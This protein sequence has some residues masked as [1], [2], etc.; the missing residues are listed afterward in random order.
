MLRLFFSRFIIY[1]I[2][3]LLLL[4]VTGV[5]P[6]YE[7]SGRLKTLWQDTYVYQAIERVSDWVGIAED[8]VKPAAYSSGK[9]KEKP[10]KP[11]WKETY[12]HRSITQ[13]DDWL[14]TSR[15]LTADDLKGRIILLD[16]W[17]FCCINCIHVI[18]DLQY[19]EEKFGHDLTVIGV[20]SAKFA[21]ERDR[22]NIRAA[23]LRYGVEHPVVN[24]A[25]FQVWQSFGA[26]AWPTF[27]LISPEGRPVEI[28]SGEGHRDALEERISD[29]IEEYEGRLNN[30][31]LPI[32]LEADKAP[33]ML[34]NFPGKLAH[35]PSVPAF[36]NQ[37]ILFIANSSDH[38]IL[39]TTLDGAILTTIGSGERGYQDGDYAT[40]Q[41]DKPQGL[42]YRDNALYVAD[43]SNHVLRKIDLASGEVTTIAGTGK[44]GYN[45]RASK[46]DA[47]ST[48]LASPWD[49]AFYPDENHITIAMA[50]THQLWVYD[51]KNDKV[52]VLAGNG[53]ESIDDGEY[54][55]NSLSQPSGLSVHD[56]KLYFVD[57][58]T[59]SLRVLEDGAITTLIGTGLF[60]FGFED[61]TRGIG[62][63]QHPL[64]IHADDT[65]VY[66]A[67]S[68]NHAIRRY[69]YATGAITTVS[70]DGKSGDAETTAPARYNEPNDILKIGDAFY[71]ADTNNHSIR[72]LNSDNTINNINL[73]YQSSDKKEQI[74][75]FLPNLLVD[76]PVFA[77]AANAP[78]TVE[79]TLPKGWKI[80]EE[81]PTWLTLFEE[82]GDKYTPITSLTREDLKSLNA[83]L[84][85][86]D[87]EKTYR[88]Q[89]TLYYCEDKAGSIC[90]VQSADQRFTTSESGNTKITI[91]P[92]VPDA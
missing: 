29:L 38:Q 91:A 16:F 12:M 42:L 41:F 1:Y 50:G 73:F 45:R 14:N 15:P 24:D 6:F 58:E 10:S 87:A 25:A 62:Q 90:L 63:L 77:P 80:N 57:S 51:I 18:P 49:L 44:Q 74:E 64:G 78:I 31:P 68:Y 70:G 36:N 40:A 72:V 32:A 67:D 4:F 28:Y 84:P 69:D 20:H 17:T 89:T 3:A 48:R 39:A 66:I 59:S 88:L 5:I 71:I 86:L 43:T 46:V 65:G 79:I 34:L 83:T 81:A 47:R 52:S 13:V 7:L 55:H 56:G 82:Q 8:D 61:G 26:R 30:T 19:L 33:N 21:N 22:E 9:S 54:P 92:E 35:A 60:D 85:A 11:K 76:V 75:E 27:V 37:D 53:R 23:M 2:L